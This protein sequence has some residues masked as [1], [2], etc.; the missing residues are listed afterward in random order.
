VAAPVLGLVLNRL[1]DSGYGS[2]AGELSNATAWFIAVLLGLSNVIL[3]PVL[4]GQTM[5]M[6]LA[7]LRIVTMDGRQPSVTKILLRHTVGYLLTMATLGL[8][9]ALAAITPRGR[10]LHDY[11]SGT[12]VIYATKHNI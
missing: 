2:A 7:G 8:G 4:S 12:M 3:F 11:L 5:G 1:I 9:F 6:M 10:A